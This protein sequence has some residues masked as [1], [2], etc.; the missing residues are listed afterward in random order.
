MNG[1]HRAFADTNLAAYAAV[2][3]DFGDFKSF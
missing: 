3:D 1:L 2:G